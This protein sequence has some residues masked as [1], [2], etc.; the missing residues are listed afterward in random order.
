M[1]TPILADA[2]RHHIWATLR[3]I[4]VCAELDP[5]QLDTSAKGTYG[6]ILETMRHLVGADA[7]YLFVL[8][9]GRY[10]EVEEAEMDLAAL[11]TV[12]ERDGPGWDEIIAADLDPSR[13]VVRHRDDGS[14]SSAPLGVRLAQVIHHGTDHR[15]QICTDL[16]TI[17]VTPPEIDVWDYAASEDRLSETPPTA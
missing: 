15:S 7:S 3:L 12:I 13:V 14:T 2:F 10:P 5:G 16:T 1:T 4:D 17:G 8:S 9:D 11:R 6:S